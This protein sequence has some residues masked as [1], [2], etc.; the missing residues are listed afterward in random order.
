MEK[1]IINAS[2]VSGGGAKKRLLKTVQYLSDEFDIIVIKQKKIEVTG[3]KIINI[4]DKGIFFFRFIYD[5]LVPFIL[6]GFGYK[7]MYLLGSF[8]FGFFSGNVFWN[9]TNIE[10]FRDF[11]KA[12]YDWK[13]TF[14][15]KI[16]YF[17]FKVSK[18]PKVLI[19]QSNY[20][21]NLINSKFNGKYNIVTVSNGVSLQSKV[22][23]SASRSKQAVFVGQM[24]RYKRIEMIIKQLN[25]TG[26]F[27]ESK[28]LLIGQTDW[29]LDYYRELVELIQVLKL[30]DN[31]IILGQLQPDKV[32]HYISHSDF[33][34]YANE[35]DNCPNCVLE[36]LSFGVPV[37]AWKNEVIVELAENGGILIVNEVLKKEQVKEVCSLRD[38]FHFEYSWDSH[39][40]KVVSIIRHE[41]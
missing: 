33:M 41:N 34:V 7:K 15:L 39:F 19:S 14:R 16:L 1:L 11:S 18:K 23:F 3:V 10:P 38:E 26:F 22:S 30:K 13:Q 4:P 32:L 17:L 37:L 27:T 29:D 9:I 40:S 20:T 12:G 2:S 25:N 21:K 28:L 6:R 31:V 24:V 35:Y 5:L 8:Y 36:S